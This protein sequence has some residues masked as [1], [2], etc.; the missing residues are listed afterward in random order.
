MVEDSYIYLYCIAGKPPALPSRAETEQGLYCIR[1]AELYATVAKVPAAEFG[2]EQLERHIADPVWLKR[3]AERHEQVIEGV[4]QDTAVI[5]SEVGTVFSGEHKVQAFLAQYKKELRE[6]LQTL[7]GCE[8]WSVKICC[9]RNVLQRY[10]AE[11]NP[12]VTELDQQIASA[13]AGKGYLLKRKREQLI[14]ETA[15]ESMTAVRKLFT[16]VFRALDIQLKFKPSSKNPAVPDE[17]PLLEL[18]ALVGQNNLQEFL[19]CIEMLK[20]EY[21]GQ[22]FAFDCSGPWPPYNFSQITAP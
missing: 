3:Q 20:T 2:R 8:E 22:G 14:E 12:A 16:E 10:T 11:N 1:N 5:P 6:K 21:H 17:E 15:D 4:M 7:E 9:D 19:T 18:A 13:S